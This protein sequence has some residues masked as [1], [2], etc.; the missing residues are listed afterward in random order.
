VTTRRLMGLNAM[1]N[2]MLRL[3]MKSM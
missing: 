1:L 2:P 3:L